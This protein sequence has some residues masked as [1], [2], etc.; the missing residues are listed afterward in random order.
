[1]HYTSN[2]SRGIIYLVWGDYNVGL[3]NRSMNSVKK[4]GYRCCV[5]HVNSDLEGFEKK[6]LMYELSPYDITCY[7]DADTIVKAN[8]DYGFD[9]AEKYDIAC[10]IAPASSAYCAMPNPIKDIMHNDL[11]QYRSG[12]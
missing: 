7:L 5:C 8:I 4:L 12:S 2:K 6:S 3:L 11:P 1:M 9:M 10:C